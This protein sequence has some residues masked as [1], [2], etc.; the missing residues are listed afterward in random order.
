ME[1][2]LPDAMHQQ[3][4]AYDA[5]RGDAALIADLNDL[6]EDALRE[7]GAGAGTAPHTVASA[8]E[9]LHKLLADPIENAGRKVMEQ[10]GT[11]VG[12]AAPA[13]R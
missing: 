10:V 2:G 7:V 8:I 11:L 6:A 12:R 1:H 3:T 9:G 13:H 4:M 5:A